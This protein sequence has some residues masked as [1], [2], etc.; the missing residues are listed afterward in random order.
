MLDAL[1]VA[2]LPIYPGLG[3]APSVLGC[4][5]SGLVHTQWLKVDGIRWRY[6]LTDPVYF[7]IAIHS[8]SFVFLLGEL[9]DKTIAMTLNDLLRVL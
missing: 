4:I 8:T 5:P 1:P 9:A 6:W 3:Q 7:Q 2:T